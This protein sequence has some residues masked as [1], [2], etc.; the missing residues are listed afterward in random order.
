MDPFQKKLKSGQ[1]KAPGS[2]AQG[3]LDGQLLIAMPVMED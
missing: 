3:Y 1:S 2:P